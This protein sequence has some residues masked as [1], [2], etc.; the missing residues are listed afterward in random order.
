MTYTTDTATISYE[1]VH[2]EKRGDHIPLLFLH[3]ALGTRREFDRLKEYYPDRMLIL[4]D[5]PSHGESTTTLHAI[6]MHDLAMWMRRLVIEHLKIPT[7][8]IIG[9][10]M[11]GYVAITLALQEPRLVRSIVS[12]AMKFYW[13]QT[14]ISEALAGLDADAIKARSEKA[15]AALSAI[16]EPN[17]LHRTAALASSVIRSFAQK[18]LTEEDVKKLE[19]PLLVSVGDND[20]MVTPEEVTRLYG[21]LAREKAYLAIHPNSPHQ[22]SKLDLGSFTFSN[23]LVFGGER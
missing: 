12:H 23:R 10:S 22:I 3:S 16:H 17:D 15:Y 2:E 19:C 1:L 4:P 9:Y 5:L 6:T 7:V 20:T 11:G 14:A 8:D 18:Q 13:T 21:A